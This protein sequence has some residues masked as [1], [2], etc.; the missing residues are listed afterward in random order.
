MSDSEIVLF[1][2]SGPL[3][4]Q[5]ALLRSRWVRAVD[6]LWRETLLRRKLLEGKERRRAERRAKNLQKIVRK[7]LSE[8]H[9][10]E[11]E[12][13]R[14]AEAESGERRANPGDHPAKRNSRSSP[15]RKY[16]S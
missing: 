16:T 10:I 1:S 14:R 9:R 4:A 2:G 8:Y 7:A 11:L 5:V 12:W 15:F 13:R 3:E 6:L